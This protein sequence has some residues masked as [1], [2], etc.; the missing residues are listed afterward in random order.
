[1]D[2]LSITA[3]VV[4]FI[5]VAKRIK[6]SVDKTGSNRR[7]LKELTDNVV[8][9]VAKLHKYH[10]L[11][12]SCLDDDSVCSLE[13]LETQL[14]NVLGRCMQRIKPR[15]RGRL[16]S[17]KAY[18]IAWLQ[19][20]EIEA[21][22]VRLEQCVA[23]VHRCFTYTAFTRMEDNLL[24]F[25]SE[26][27]SRM[28]QMEGLVTQLL[29]NSHTTGVY[30]SSLL[31]NAMPN[32][33]EFQFLHLQAQKIVIN[34]NYISATHTFTELPDSRPV[35]LA[36]IVQ[37]TPP[38]SPMRTAMIKV[39]QL[40]QLIQL[41]P[42][43]LSDRE[44]ATELLRI[45]KHLRDLG[46]MEDAAAINSCATAIYRAL[47]QENPAV[48]MP[49]VF[50]GLMNF[51]RLRYGTQMG[52][53]AVESAY[54]LQKDMTPASRQESS[55]QLAWSM[56]HY[57]DHLLVNGHCEE[58]VE[59]AKDALAI[60]RNVSEHYSEYDS[61]VVWEASGQEHAVLSSTCLVIRTFSMA[62]Q[63][64]LCLCAFA[65]SLAAVG[66]YSEAFMVGTE[67]ISCFTA[68]AQYDPRSAVFPRWVRAGLANR[69]RWVSIIRPPSQRPSFSTTADEE[70]LGALDSTEHL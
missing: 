2:P 64:G 1:M 48:Y 7:R 4:S 65:Q 55:S 9:E 57:A 54:R 15:K 6:D 16:S 25:S 19:N 38:P 70:N 58:S 3:A 32:G 12:I 35:E 68:L 49:Y 63:E 60:Q 8:E 23:H 59:H 45:G 28:K 5:D 36:T 30:P 37:E 61:L 42:A 34:L 43:S 21:E 50:W 39:L 47:M 27:Q 26:H 14:H 13:S 69:S 41:E 56:C 62:V 22:M 44:G 67:I 17:I 52:L 51:A 10:H 40:Q 66:R 11:K 20:T 33:I 53:D 31:D 29:L 18:V 24:I 46:L